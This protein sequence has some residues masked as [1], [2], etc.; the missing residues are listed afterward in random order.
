MVTDRAAF[1]AVIVTLPLLVV[2]MTGPASAH[3]DL[4]GST[5]SPGQKLVQPPEEVTLE[6]SEPI[7]PDFTSLTLTRGDEEAVTLTPRVARGVVTAAVPPAQADGPDRTPAGTFVKWT[8][9]YR[10]VSD[11][12]HTVAGRIRFA[13]RPTPAPSQPTPSPPA[14]TPPASEPAGAA[15]GQS[16]TVEGQGARTLTAAVLGAVVLVGGAAMMF[17]LSRRRAESDR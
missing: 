9:A 8:L 7:D 12:G 14:S 16:E 15:A 3:A 11:D 6:F 5:P 1:V 4:L 13:V 17:F 10:V 2:V